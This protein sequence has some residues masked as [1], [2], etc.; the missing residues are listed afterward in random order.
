MIWDFAF[1]F[2]WFDKND[3]DVYYPALKVTVLSD[4]KPSLDS[5][6]SLYAGNFTFIVNAHKHANMRQFS[7]RRTKII[8]NDAKGF[9]YQSKSS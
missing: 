4:P 9:L 7:P 1:W 8:P 5:F 3:G 6:L 2:V